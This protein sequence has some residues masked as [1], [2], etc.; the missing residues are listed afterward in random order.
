VGGIA[1][2]YGVSA[3]EI[4]RWNQLADAGRIFP[5]DRLRV[6]LAAPADREEGQGG[7]R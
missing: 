1:K 5:G 7:F 6:A 4:M 2:R 3:G